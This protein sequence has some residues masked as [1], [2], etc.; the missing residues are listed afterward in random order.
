M[1]PLQVWQSSKRGMVWQSEASVP[2]GNVES[3]G[4][5]PLGV[6]LLRQQE[7]AVAVPAP[8]QGPQVVISEKHHTTVQVRPRGV[9]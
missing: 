4:A 6:E 2:E 5:R 3:V 7:V 1:D 9:F 8:Q